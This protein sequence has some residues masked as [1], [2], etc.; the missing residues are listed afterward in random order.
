MTTRLQERRER[1]EIELV[2]FDLIAS[3]CVR[4]LMVISGL[5]AVVMVA[6]GASWPAPTLSGT[7]AAVSLRWLCRS[8]NT[9]AARSA[10]LT[11]FLTPPEQPTGRQPT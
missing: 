9:R 6:T 1:L 11:T 8:M 7:L 4:G 10:A 5:V 2:R 3:Y